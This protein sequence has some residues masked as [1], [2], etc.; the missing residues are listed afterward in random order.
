MCC[1][2]RIVCS[3]VIFVHD[4]VGAEAA[5]ACAHPEPGSVILLENLRFHAEEDGYGVDSEGK[6][7]RYSAFN[8][9]TL[10]IAAL[11]YSTV[12]NVLHLHM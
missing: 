5:K 3:E 6:L 12:L 9:H 8:P 10:P 2:L 11:L 1:A 7:V 4:C